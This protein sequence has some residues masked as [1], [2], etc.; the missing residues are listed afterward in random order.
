MQDRE[1]EHSSTKE[2]IQSFLAK[3]RSVTVL[4]FV[5]IVMDMALNMEIR[6]G[7]HEISIYQ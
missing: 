6:Q 2:E 3:E 7:N 5:C 4:V 1:K